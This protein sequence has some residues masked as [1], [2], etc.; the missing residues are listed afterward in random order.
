MRNHCL[1]NARVSNRIESL[2]EIQRGNPQGNVELVALLCQE[3]RCKQVIVTTEARSEASLIIG[4]R[5][6]QEAL[7]PIAHHLAEE[8]VEN[9]N[10][11]NGSI[12]FRHS[13]ITLLEKD[14]N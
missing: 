1:P 12:V 13:G 7:N 6:I 3:A 5:S 4:L 9:W 14:A 2:F 10:D 8:F 11:S